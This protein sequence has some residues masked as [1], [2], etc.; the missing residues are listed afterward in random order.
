MSFTLSYFFT[1]EAFQVCRNIC[2][3]PMQLMLKTSQNNPPKYLQLNNFHIRSTTSLQ[4][5]T[6]IRCDSWLHKNGKD[7]KLV[8]N[9]EKNWYRAFHP[10]S[11]WT[12]FQRTWISTDVNSLPLYRCF[13]NFS[14]DSFSSSVSLSESE[15]NSLHFLSS[16]SS[17]ESESDFSASRFFSSVCSTLC[18]SESEFVSCACLLSL[19][20]EH[21][22]SATLIDVDR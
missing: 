17:S 22:I 21:W 6:D 10:R 5:H 16:V 15:S 13:S 9:I 2:P 3:D 19:S 11:W 18:Q 12:R 7:T 20:Q 1:F 14:G 8:P 4:S